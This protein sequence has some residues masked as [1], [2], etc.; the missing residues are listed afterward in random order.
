MEQRK[1]EF[2][3]EFKAMAVEALVK[4]SF[5]QVHG[6]MKLI[7]REGNVYTEAESNAIVGFLGEL[8]YRDV[9]H[10]FDVMPQLV[11]EVTPK[12]PDG[13]MQ[14]MPAEAIPENA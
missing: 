6:V 5:S 9:S 13:P 2:K 4:L 12:S 1:F 11:T 7:K 10:I 3:Q 14:A 8:P